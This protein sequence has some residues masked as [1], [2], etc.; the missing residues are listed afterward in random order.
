MHNWL[1]VLHDISVNRKG[2]VPRRPG[3]CTYLVTYRCNARCKMCDSW[4]IKPGTELTPA[5]VRTVFA[6]IGRLDV[7]RLT[8]GEP[9]GRDDFAELAH[10]V[11]EAS[12]P[13]VLHITSNGSQPD[14]IVAFVEQFPL[15]RK[16]RFMISFDGMPEEHDASRG[17][18][19]T[20]E[21][22]EE[23]VRKLVELRT[24][25]GLGVSINHTVISKRSLEDH[26]GLVERFA[27]L[28]V[29]VQA[30]LA[31]S[32]S[33]MYGLKRQRSKAVDLIP[34]IGYP[35]H[36]NLQDADCVAFVERLLARL[37]DVRDPLVRFGKRYYLRG[38]LARLRNEPNP[39]PKPHCVALR[40]HLRILPDG[41]VPVCQ[42][43]TERVGN[44]LHQSFE[45]VWHHPTTS[46]ARTWVDACPGCWAECEVMPSALYTGDL[47]LSGR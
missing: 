13:A 11:D 17:R 32:D 46:E 47:L 14:R 9:F 36:P 19:V 2:G 25:R 20:F 30:V 15:P 12:R 31:Y 38:L 45:E 33:A 6:K 18:E 16:L 24:R 28:G 27:P 43:N 35:L 7:V 26:V 3:W 22:A 23:T 1:H 21:I 44:L 40:S 10:A 8:G 39:Q 41:S 29:D 5:Q 42:F 34:E 4:R 37:D